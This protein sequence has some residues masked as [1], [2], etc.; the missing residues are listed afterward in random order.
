MPAFI[1]IVATAGLMLGLARYRV[2]VLLP[3]AFAIV[4]FAVATGFTASA[5]GGSVFLTAI[6]GLASLQIGYVL[7]L[8]IGL[9]RGRKAIGQARRPQKW[10]LALRSE[11]VRRAMRFPRS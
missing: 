3:A 7:G 5:N 1:A 9:F 2:V 11:S 8:V 6:F 10:A 4:I